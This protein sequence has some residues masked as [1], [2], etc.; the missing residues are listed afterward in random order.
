MT[1]GRE[2]G[3]EGTRYVWYKCHE[4]ANGAGEGVVRTR[5]SEERG[6]ES[7]IMDNK[8][9]DLRFVEVVVDDDE[10]GGVS[11]GPP[12]QFTHNAQHH[13]TTHKP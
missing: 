3:R 9:T 5:A 10:S 6:R 8:G 11:M 7:N 13:T 4:N 1:G 12:E 2:G